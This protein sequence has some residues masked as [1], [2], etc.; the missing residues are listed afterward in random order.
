MPS[1]LWMTLALC[2]TLPACRQTPAPASGPTVASINAA[3]TAKILCSG[4]FVA[5]RAPAEILRD[6]MR[7]NAQAVLAS[8]DVRVR[9]Q[10]PAVIIN[11]PGI[12][13]EAVYR[14][15]LGCT[16]L[17]GDSEQTVYRQ[18]S[19]PP[20]PPAAP[21][22][23]PWPAGDAG[24]GPLPADVNAAALNAAM[25]Y[26]FSEPPP[27][28]DAQAPKNI[29][30]T[31]AVTIVYGGHLLAE[32]YAPPFTAATPLL[33]YSMTKSI[34]N[35]LTGILVGEGRLSVAAPPRVPEWP[36]G[37][38]RRAVTL[39]QML[40]MSTGL[41]FVEAY[42]D[43]PVDTV[44]MLYAQ[45]DAA[46]YAA[47]KALIHPPGT[48]WQY[49]S[50]TTN[51]ISRAL[52]YAVGGSLA[53]YLTFP[54]THLFN[55]IGA[56]SA[57]LEPDAS[58]TFVGSTF[59]YATARD[60]AR[61]GLLYLDDGV[62]NGERILPKGWVKYTATPAP[63]AP[64]GRYGA[65]F[66]LNAGDPADPAKRSWPDIPTDAFAMIGYQGQAVVIIPSRDVVIVRL[67]ETMPD[68]PDPGKGDSDAFSLDH[69]VALVLKALPPKA[70]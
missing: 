40:H 21:S 63:H 31:R 56:D 5:G 68:P 20:A 48:V 15:G 60:W 7:I 46:H 17:N 65:Q 24:P 47:G 66:W 70:S 29:R 33:G 1:K 23:A 22:S 37:D 45:P 59:M 39:D 64:D 18:F 8:G 19:E 42:S 10:P 3:V 41:E 9:R 49:S 16:L 44:L 69:F 12:H 54:R 62:W 27:G 25:T 67:G 34:I 30:D 38:P 57:V 51:L 61:L 4:V 26:A 14:P 53:D 43:K 6:D 11:E 58:G 50:G 35:A 32:R 55:R 28:P 13:V 36:A 52:R 2:A